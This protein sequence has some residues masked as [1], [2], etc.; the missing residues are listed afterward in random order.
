MTRTSYDAIAA[1]YSDLFRHELETRPI[2]RAALA[3]FA[4]LVRNANPCSIVDV[5][6]GPG[7]VTAH[8]GGLGAD[9]FGIDLSPGMLAVARKA[10]PELRFDE[11]SMLALDI[12]DGSVGGV[13]AWYSI[14]H[15]PDELLPQV[16]AEFHRIL[17]PGGSALLGFQV[18]HRPLHLTEALGYEVSLD[19]HRRQPEHIAELLTEA[20][21]VIH[22][23]VI[24]EPAEGE[25]IEPT[26]K[27]YL[28]ARKPE[29]L[30]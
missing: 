28:F 15:I 14:I 4:E 12:P 17:V 29:T 3:A 7:R 26:Q 18:G 20:G 24:R 11:G 16:F 5:G 9:I 2:E 19:F 27:A 22:A 23:R 10:Y 25:G 30:Q 1:D 8:L 21:L 6:C 13:L